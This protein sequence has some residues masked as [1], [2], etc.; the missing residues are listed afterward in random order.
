MNRCVR[1]VNFLL[2]EGWFYVGAVGGA[3]HTFPWGDVNARSVVAGVI[4][5]GGPGASRIIEEY[6][7]K[8]SVAF[9]ARRSIFPGG[10]PGVREELAL[11]LDGPC[12]HVADH[13]FGGVTEAMDIALIGGGLNAKDRADVLGI[14]L[15]DRPPVKGGRGDGVLVGQDAVF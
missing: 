10:Y 1:I 6:A 3:V 11:G 15:H 2:P 9:L 14:V 5:V 7:V 12:A 13:F 4:G 8:Y